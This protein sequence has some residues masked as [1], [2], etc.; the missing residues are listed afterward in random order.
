MTSITFLS[1]L[2]RPVLNKDAI[3]SSGTLKMSSV[4]LD[5]YF[6]GVLDSYYVYITH[7]WEGNYSQQIITCCIY[8][9]MHCIYFNLRSKEFLPIKGQP[10]GCHVWQN[11][12][13][14]VTSVQFQDI[15][16]QGE[17]NLLLLCL[18]YFVNLDEWMS[19]KVWYGVQQGW[20]LSPYLSTICAERNIMSFVMII[21]IEKWIVWTLDMINREIV[22]LSASS[23]SCECCHAFDVG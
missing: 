19:I 4:S 20:S 6:F 10:Q 23:S 3:L 1:P 7:S 12:G 17:Y 11:P 16:G 14:T 15:R 18:K 8:Q 5:P 9:G 2:I 13:F 21:S 22:L